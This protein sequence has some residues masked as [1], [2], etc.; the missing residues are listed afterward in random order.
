MDQYLHVMVDQPPDLVPDLVSNLRQFDCENDKGPRS[1]H[2]T[3][4]IVH[5]VPAAETQLFKSPKQNLIEAHN[6]RS[7]VTLILEPVNI[8]PL[9]LTS[10]VLCTDV[11]EC[12]PLSDK[13]DPSDETH[14]QSQSCDPVATSNQENGDELKRE[15][16]KEIGVLTDVC[17]SA[18][19]P[20][21]EI[22]SLIEEQIP[23]Y[24]LRADTITNFCGY[25]NEDW[26]QTPLIPLDQDIELTTE[27]IAETLKYFILCA[28]RVTQMNFLCA[29]RFYVPSV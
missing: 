15:E 9:R 19:L 14:Y 20:E 11:V 21:V 17:N 12:L 10:D 28:E 24:R 18:D 8:P 7:D 1:L 27:Q 13:L 26:I 23:K 2:H 16:T 29:E 3:P 22:L 5:I 4:D 25:E 6:G